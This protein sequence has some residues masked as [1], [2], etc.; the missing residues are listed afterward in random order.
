MQVP[1][2]EPLSAV[3]GSVYVKYNAGSRSSYVSEYSGKDRG[4]LLSF[5]QIQVPPP[6]PPPC[7]WSMLE[8]QE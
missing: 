5:G 4:V 2:A 7:F 1:G 8:E 3:R 6:P